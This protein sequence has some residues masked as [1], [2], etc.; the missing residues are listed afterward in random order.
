VKIPGQEAFS[1]EAASY[2][3]TLIDG[4]QNWV[5]TI[6]TRPDPEK[7]RRIRATLKEAHDRLHSRM[8]AHRHV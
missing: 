6:A 2:M 7:L 8:Q 4:T 5:D 1:M 3:M